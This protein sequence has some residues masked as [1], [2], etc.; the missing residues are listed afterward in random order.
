MS[1]TS[2]ER[3]LQRIENAL[4]RLAQAIQRLPDG[5]FTADISDAVTR[6]SHEALTMAHNLLRTRTEAAVAGIDRLL[7]DGRKR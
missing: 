2:R 1:Q 3:A 6:E 4:G 7:N 5:A